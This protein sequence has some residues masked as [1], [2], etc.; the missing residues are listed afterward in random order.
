MN[1]FLIFDCRHP[2]YLHKPLQ[3]SPSSRILFCIQLFDGN[4]ALTDLQEHMRDISH[5]F[6][7]FYKLNNKISEQRMSQQTNRGRTNEN[8]LCLQPCTEKH[9]GESVIGAATAAGDYLR[10]CCCLSFI[11]HRFWVHLWCLCGRLWRSCGGGAGKGQTGNAFQRP[12]IPPHIYRHTHTH[13]DEADILWVS[14][15]A[16]RTWRLRLRFSDSPLH[17]NILHTRGF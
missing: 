5:Y 8:N 7:A 6:L 17:F 12:K 9:P 16:G 11:I 15:L 13:T 10:L 3:S 1:T 2:C 4:R 14:M